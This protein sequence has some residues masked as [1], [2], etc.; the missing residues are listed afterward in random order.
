MERPKK[1]KDVE[2]NQISVTDNQDALASNVAI[3]YDRTTSR[4]ANN[5]C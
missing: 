5:S 4:L 1:A 3:H 2:V